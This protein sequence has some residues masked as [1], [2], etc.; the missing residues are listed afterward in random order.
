VCL[1]RGQAVARD[2]H[3][4]RGALGEIE[5]FSRGLKN[6]RRKAG[7]SSSQPCIKMVGDCR[8]TRVWIGYAP[9]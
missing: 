3:F 4:V 8:S 1:G 2:P 5:R 6:E 9:I 7:M